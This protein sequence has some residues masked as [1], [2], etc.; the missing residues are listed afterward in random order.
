MGKVR[1]EGQKEEGGLVKRNR[2]TFKNNEASIRHRDR[3]LIKKQLKKLH[4]LSLESLEIA[5]YDKFISDLNYMED[6]KKI[7]GDV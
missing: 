4:R 2:K 3:R 6:Y 1:A 5:L 7:Y